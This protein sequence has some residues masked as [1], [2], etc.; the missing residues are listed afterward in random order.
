MAAKPLTGGFFLSL[1]AA[2]DRHSS[3]LKRHG[4]S[5]GQRYTRSFGLLLQGGVEFV[6]DLHSY[7]LTH[8]AYPS[9]LCLVA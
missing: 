4:N 6:A 2:I 8:K 1:G 3:L 9:S 5:F 7:S